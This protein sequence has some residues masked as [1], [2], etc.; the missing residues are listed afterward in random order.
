MIAL[1]LAGCAIDPGGAYLGGVGDPV[2]GAALYAPAQF[3]DFGRYAGDPAGAAQAAAQLE[4]L[5]DSFRTDPRYAVQVD[6]GVVAALDQARF[7]LRAAIGI[8][9]DA[10][11]GAVIRRLRAAAAALVAGSP[12][13]AEAALASAEFS[14]PPRAVL[15]ALARAPDLPSAATA[16]NLAAAE[17]GRLDQRR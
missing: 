9:P 2:R 1:F 10:P 7:E 15:A 5:A 11:P 16:A 3:G 14:A 12:V 4:F 13:R 17:I 6:Q 8:A